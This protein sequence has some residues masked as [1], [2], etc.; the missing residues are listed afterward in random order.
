MPKLMTLEEAIGVVCPGDTVSFGGFNL[1]NKP[2]AAVRQLIRRSVTDLTVICAAP[3][4]LD[5]D[6]LVGA[7]CVSALLVQSV[8]AED[9]A[10]IAPCFR[11]ACQAGTLDVV[12][13]DQGVVN[14]GLR[15]AKMGLDS[16]QAL[17]AD[18]TSAAKHGGRWLTSGREPFTGRE[19]TY[20]RPLKPDV[21][22]V[23][24]HVADTDGRALTKGS[25]YNDALLTGAAKAV[26]VTAER[27]VPS[28][29][30]HRFEGS[31]V[32]WRDN[33]VAVVWA[34]FGAHSTACG[35]EYEYDAQHITAYC[36][37]VRR[38]GFDGYRTTVLGPAEGDYLDNVG[39]AQ[40][41]ALRH[42]LLPRPEQK[43]LL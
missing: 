13:V 37:T 23:H 15:A 29:E 39:L 6:M 18:G 32:S 30:L 33:T 25:I 34:P 19:T 14:A 12:D 38:V 43:T 20:V 16:I 1:Q 5:V 9:L 7:G 31:P 11:R 26:V 41:L 21:A 24:A 42:H 3:S 8:S 4:S 27:V 2:M 22:F 28:G 10:A 36:D 17:G 35:G 40:L